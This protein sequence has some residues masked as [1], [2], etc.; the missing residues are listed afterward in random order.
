MPDI[1]RPC[2]LWPARLLCPWDSPGKHTGVGC[3]FLLHVTSYRWNQK[4]FFDTHFCLGWVTYPLVINFHEWRWLYVFLPFPSP[5]W[6]RYVSSAFPHTLSWRLLSVDFQT[7]TA[8]TWFRSHVIRGA[9]H[10][11]PRDTAPLF[12][13]GL[14]PTRLGSPSFWT[15]RLW[16]HSRNDRIV[17]TQRGF[18]AVVCEHDV[19]YRTPCTVKGPF[20]ISEWFINFASLPAWCQVSLWH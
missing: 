3:H 6:L 14:R 19:N 10:R 16:P 15:V 20:L 18:S 2:G 12:S 8:T 11:N 7:S 17:F 9:S 5:P 4:V 1:F 13:T